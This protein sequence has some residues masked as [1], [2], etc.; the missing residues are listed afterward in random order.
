MIK[1]P[2][3]TTPMTTRCA[4]VNRGI[5]P[6]RQPRQT[7]DPRLT[8]EQFPEHPLFSWASRTAVPGG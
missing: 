6:S 5:A 2:E 1:A 8:T 4:R 7:P 3:T